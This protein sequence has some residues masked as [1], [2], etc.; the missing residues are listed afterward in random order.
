[1]RDFSIDLIWTKL[2]IAITAIGGW[3]GINWMLAVGTAYAAFLWFPFTP[4][5]LITVIISL[6][7][8]KRLFPNDEKTLKVLQKELDKLK[9]A[10]KRKR[11][12][13]KLKKEEKKKARKE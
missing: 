8:L 6:F 9:T 5:K 13:R 12:E 1:M 4:E 11:A 7:L 2:Q 10:I 3:L